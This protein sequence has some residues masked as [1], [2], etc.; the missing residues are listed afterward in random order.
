MYSASTSRSY[1]IFTLSPVSEVVHVD[2]NHNDLVG[3]VDKDWTHL[4]RRVKRPVPDASEG[5]VLSTVESSKLRRG[6]GGAANR[7]HDIGL[8]RAAEIELLSGVAG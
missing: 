1:V 3:L 7:A 2:G 6:P 4:P 8:G 5:K